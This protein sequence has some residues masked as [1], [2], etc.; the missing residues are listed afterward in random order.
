[1]LYV[2]IEKRVEFCWIIRAEGADVIYTT[3]QWLEIIDSHAL[4]V[5]VAVSALFLEK[6]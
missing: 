2:E 5:Y 3:N 6:L 4:F 1:M